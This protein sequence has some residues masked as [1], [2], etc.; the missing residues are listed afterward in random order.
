MRNWKTIGRGLALCG[1]L[2]LIAVSMNTAPQRD[3][4]V[5]LTFDVG[6]QEALADSTGLASALSVSST[7]L[8]TQTYTRP[9]VTAID[10]DT[11]WAK[12]VVPFMDANDMIWGAIYIDS[13]PS[14]AQPMGRDLSD[15]MYFWKDTVQFWVNTDSGYVQIY[16]NDAD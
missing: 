5:P 14:T 3:H 9:R 12:I 6:W 4:V 2:T 7:K 1:I 11:A 10:G 8:L 15:S 13:L 16:F